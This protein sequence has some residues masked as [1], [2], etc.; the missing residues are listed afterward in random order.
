MPSNPYPL[1]TLAATPVQVNSMLEQRN[2]EFEKS[3][4]EKGA[5]FLTD[6]AKVKGA[7][8]TERYR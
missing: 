3:M 6:A 1:S 4:A 8:Q 5:G 2:K 7:V